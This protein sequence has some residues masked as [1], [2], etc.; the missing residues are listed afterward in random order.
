MIGTVD[1]D[2]I[3]RLANSTILFD[4]SDDLLTISIGRMGNYYAIGGKTKTLFVYEQST[5]KVVA[6]FNNFKDSI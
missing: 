5:N 3:L 2:G 4:D 1:Q 6:K